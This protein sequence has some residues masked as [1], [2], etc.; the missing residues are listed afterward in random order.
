MQL[1]LAGVPGTSFQELVQP[2]NTTTLVEGN[3]NKTRSDTSSKFSKSEQPVNK[4]SVEEVN[5]S[6]V[7]FSQSMNDR[8][9]AGE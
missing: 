3:L 1:L 9:F 5:D 7:P 2:N 4:T 6:A 8:M